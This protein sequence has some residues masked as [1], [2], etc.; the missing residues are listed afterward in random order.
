[1]SPGPVRGA[2]RPA[3]RR[4]ALRPRW[5]QTCPTRLLPPVPTTAA[6]RPGCHTAGGQGRS[7][8]TEPVGTWPGRARAATQPWREPGRSGLAS[9]AAQQGG[10]LGLAG[11][12]GHV[13]VSGSE[14]AALAS[15]SLSALGVSGRAEPAAVPC[16]PVPWLSATA[17]PAPD[18]KPAPRGG[19]VSVDGRLLPHPCPLPYGEDFRESLGL[20]CGAWTH[21]SEGDRGRGHRAEARERGS[22]CPRDRAV[23]VAPCP[24]LAANRLLAAGGVQCGREAAPEPG[25]V[26]TPSSVRTPRRPV[27]R[28]CGHGAVPGCPHG[29][30]GQPRFSGA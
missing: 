29:H 25:A 2:V 27:F 17:V 14:F 13:R 8:R 19:P 10:G 24:G 6:T 26:R 4:P 20:G 23:A 3:H 12:G 11:A 7:H 28:P 9:P 21:R 15:T 5:P 22:H 18:R 1:M 16:P 30:E